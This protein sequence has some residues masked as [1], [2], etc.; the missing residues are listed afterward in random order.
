MRSLVWMLVL[1]VPLRVRPE[2]GGLSPRAIFCATVEECVQ[3]AREALGTGDL[4]A[5]ERAALAGLRLDECGEDGSEDRAKAADVLATVALRRGEPRL[6]RAWLQ[7]APWYARKPPVSGALQREVD[8]AVARLPRTAGLPGRYSERQRWG[9]WNE[10]HVTDASAVR[11]RFR[12]SAQAVAASACR[13]AALAMYR[14]GAA[15]DAI[16]G[17]ADLEGEAV[18]D[19]ASFV[20]ESR[21]FAFGGD[22]ACRIVFRPYPD[23]LQV[24]QESTDQ[25]CGFGGFADVSGEYLRTK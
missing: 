8:T 6:A 17:L 12:L 13:P 18:R 1:A 2:D 15:G 19:G 11:L 3:A 16:V 14:T 21:A 5:A 25:D 22:G 4:A 23:S 9:L 10:V 20:Y 7:P 24:S